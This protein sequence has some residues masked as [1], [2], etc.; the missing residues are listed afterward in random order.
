MAR[1]SPRERPS[2]QDRFGLRSPRS[3]CGLRR[4]AG[5]PERDPSC[6]GRDAQPHKQ[7]PVRQHR[8][9]RQPYRPLRPRWAVGR[10]PVDFEHVFFGRSEPLH[11]RS[12]RPTQ[13][14]LC[15]PGGVPAVGHPGHLGRQGPA[16]VLGRAER[17]GAYRPRHLCATGLLARAGRHDLPGAGVGPDR[18]ELDLRR[19]RPLALR[20][21]GPLRSPPHLRNDR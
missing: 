16:V 11:A 15:R 21:G 1:Q 12:E 3:C 14:E 8:G 4:L 2:V 17:G 5:G 13:R 19:R 9:R 20:L 18:A 6:A 7:R 10:I